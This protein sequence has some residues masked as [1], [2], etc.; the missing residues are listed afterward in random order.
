MFDRQELYAR[1]C[2]RTL[3]EIIEQMPA[4]WA[5][6]APMVLDESSASMLLLWTLIRWERRFPLT[7]LE[8]MNIDMW[9][10]TRDM[11][12]LIERDKLQKSAENNSS[13]RNADDANAKYLLRDLIDRW[14]RR[15]EDEARRL[16]HCFL[17]AEHLLLALIAGADPSLS[18]FF[19][20]YGIDYERLK[21]A[22]LRAL[23]SKTAQQSETADKN[24]SLSPPVDV[25]CSAE[26]A[27]AWGASWDKR[28]AVGMPRKF[29]IAIMMMMVTL[30]AIL[31]SIFRWINAPPIIYGV[32]GVLVFGVALGQAI[33]FG[34]KYPRAASIWT[35]VFLLPVEMGCITLFSNDIIATNN[36]L[37]RFLMAVSMMI[38]TAPLGAF[39]GYL[40]G[41]LTAGVVLV[42]ERNSSGSTPADIEDEADNQQP[43]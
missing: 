33:L 19:A 42:L 15:A 8:E 9:S 20:G 16:G 32:F 2:V 23:S 38:F 18:P 22:V 3:I 27:V 37:L 1:R 10:F 21:N 43:R 29:S 25:N 26:V 4:R 12:Q 36:I 13:I 11:D 24:A 31:F 34:G 30:F 17:G 41:G 14:L 40:A 6:R 7:L 39:F 28:P 5:A 35:G